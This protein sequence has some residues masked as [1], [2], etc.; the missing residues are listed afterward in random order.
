MLFCKHNRKETCSFV[1]I[2]LTADVHSHILPGVDDGAQEAAES[3]AIVE[4]LHRLGV[5]KMILT[6]HVSRTIYPHT[7]D[8]LKA[9]FEAFVPTLPETLRLPLL[10]RYME[11]YSEQEAAAILRI[12]RNTLR[13]RLK[14]ARAKLRDEWIET[15]EE[16]V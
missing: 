7:A 13:A 11:G 3:V 2:G 16:S 15:E 12:P 6:P 8:D 5:R 14:R 9:R 1:D 4:E 10:L